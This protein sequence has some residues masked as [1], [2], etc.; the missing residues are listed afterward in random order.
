MVRVTTRTCVVVIGR[1]ASRFH[2]FFGSLDLAWRLEL[3]L[4]VCCFDS[5]FESDRECERVRERVS[6]KSTR[7][8]AFHIP[9][10]TPSI[11]RS[12]HVTSRCITLYSEQ[13]LQLQEQSGNQAGRKSGSQHDEEGF[14]SNGTAVSRCSSTGGFVVCDANRLDGNR[15]TSGCR[16]HR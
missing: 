12:L 5:T 14:N 6:C 9:H 2:L 4:D 8:S 3:E 1:C 7:R 11:I 13:S 16:L 15:R 10:S